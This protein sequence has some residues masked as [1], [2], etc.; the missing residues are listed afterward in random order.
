MG[1]LSFGVLIIYSLEYLLANRPSYDDSETVFY[2]AEIETLL[3]SVGFTE[4]WKSGKSCKSWKVE[5]V[6]CLFETFTDSN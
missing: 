2:D 3:R 5:K 4:E 6:G 1:Y